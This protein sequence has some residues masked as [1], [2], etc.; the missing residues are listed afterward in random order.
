MRRLGFTQQLI[1]L[2]LILVGL[3]ILVMN[4]FRV[5]LVG[6]LILALVGAAF[7]A[8]YFFRRLY[9]L[10][11]PGCLLLGLALGIAGGSVLKASLTVLGLGL[12][13]LAIY[14]IDLLCRRS[15]HWWPLIPGGILVLVGLTQLP[16]MD[17]L[18]SIIWPLVLI[19]AGLLLLA[20]ALGWFKRRA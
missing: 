11:I 5:R 17:I 16:G 12:G 13:F 8:G 9:G 4:L 10:L 19:V 3:G 7:L 18:P 1:G 15:T 2:L 20:N 14:G 6:P